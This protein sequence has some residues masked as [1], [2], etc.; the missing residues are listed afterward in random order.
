MFGGLIALLVVIGFI[1]QLQWMRHARKEG[2]EALAPNALASKISQWMLE[3]KTTKTGAVTMD[4]GGAEKIPCEACL[5]T[6]TVLSSGDSKEIC[7]ICLGVG[8]HMVRRFD[9]AERICPACGGMGR[10]EMPDTGAVETCPR[11]AGRGLI[12]SQMPPAGAPDGN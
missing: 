10:L 7:P 8:F 2:A 4:A 5:G 12:R 11:C 3:T 9:P 6:G 1:L